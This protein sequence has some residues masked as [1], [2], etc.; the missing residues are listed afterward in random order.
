[1]RQKV[2]IVLRAVLPS[3]FFLLTAA[4]MV[5]AAEILGEKEI[6]FPEAGAIALGALAAPRL[7]WRTDKQSV[8]FLIG[9]C[10]C[11]GVLIVLYLPLPLAWQLIAAYLFGQAVLLA[12]RTTF[13][14]PYLGGSAARAA[15]DAFARLSRGGARLDGARLAAAQCAG[16]AGP[17]PARAVCAAFTIRCRL[18]GLVAAHPVCG[19][20]V[21]ARGGIGLAVPCLPAPFGG[22]YRIHSGGQPR[23][24][25][26]RPIGGLPRPECGMRCRCARRVLPPLRPASRAGG[27]RG[28]CRR[29]C[30]RRVHEIILA[31]RRGARAVGHARPGGGA[32]CLCAAGGGRR[33]TVYGIRL[34][35]VSSA[36]SRRGIAVR[37]IGRAG[38]S[39][40][41]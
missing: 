27:N 18:G 35:C 10:A 20:F 31:A 13:A 32:R 4:V 22:I 7:A 40:F 26:A 34:R 23:H 24:A 29:A 36:D 14:P 38:A 1:M 11:A 12:S 6:I 3:A 33:R 28:V 17:P 16:R 9:I 15:A 5:G 39:L 30:S 19:A 8:F 37:K 41:A 2:K 25:H 21:P